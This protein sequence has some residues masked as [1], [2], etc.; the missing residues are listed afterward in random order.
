MCP[1]AVIP[2]SLMVHHNHE[3]AICAHF[4]L[5]RQGIF[6]VSVRPSNTPAG[7]CH[8]W[9][10]ELGLFQRNLCHPVSVASLLPMPAH[11]EL[12]WSSAALTS[13]LRCSR[14]VGAVAFAHVYYPLLVH[15]V[16]PKFLFSRRGQL[17]RPRRCARQTL[18]FGEAPSMLVGGS[19]YGDPWR[20]N[21]SWGLANQENHI[22][23]VPFFPI[24]LSQVTFDKAVQSTWDWKTWKLFAFCALVPPTRL[25]IWWSIVRYVSLPHVEVESNCY[26]VLW[27]SKWTR[28]VLSWWPRSDDGWTEMANVQWRP[29]LSSNIM[30]PYS[31]RADVI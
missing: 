23:H 16:L 13:R 7:Q 29:H 25:R 11:G 12:G 5:F 2:D 10:E 17:S 14:L 1:P 9:R 3:S 31:R 15:V 21:K 26:M 28:I 19:F 8:L 6:P 20:K 4:I 30:T 22:K 27:G 18:G 24:P